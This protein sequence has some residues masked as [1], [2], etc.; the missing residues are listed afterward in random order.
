MRST[1][2]S[3]SSRKTI[4]PENTFS[5]IGLTMEQRHRGPICASRPSQIGIVARH[6]TKGR[7]SKSMRQRGGFTLIEIMIVVLIIAILLAVAIPNFLRARDTSRARS[8]Q[9]NLRVIASAKE[10]WAMDNRKTGSDTPTSTDLV[11]SYIKG[12]AGTLPTCPMS[13]SYSVGNMSSWPSCSVGTNGTPD[14]TDD[15]VYVE[16]GG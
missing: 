1:N 16:Q 3:Q 12:Q 10:Q 7:F 6:Q 5:I 4:V 13:G 9:G 2:P 15:H 14:L 11:T 8:C